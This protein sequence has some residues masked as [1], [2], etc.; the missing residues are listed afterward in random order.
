MRSI[1]LELVHELLR[2]RSSSWRAT[3]VFE[4][5]KH[6]ADLCLA[7]ERQGNR[8]LDCFV[9]Y[10][11]VAYDVQGINDRGTDVLL[12]YYV[13]SDNKE[14]SRFIAFQ[15]KS[16]DDL[17]A[18]TY[19]R[20]IKAQYTDSS[21]AFGD[22]LDQY[23]ILLCTNKI[24]HEDKIRQIKSAF[25][26]AEVITVI[27]PTY[28]H[29]FLALSPLRIN[30]VV[31]ILLRDDDIVYEKAINSLMQYTPTEIA[32]Y[33]ALVYEEMFS[34]SDKQNIDGI[35]DQN[36]IIDIFNKVPDYPKEYFNYLE[37][38]LTGDRSIEEDDDMD[39]LNEIVDMKRDIRI[40]FAEAVESLDGSLFSIDGDSQKYIIYLDQTLPIQAIILENMVR[41]D[42][43]DDQLLTYLFHNLR[44]L[45]HFGIEDVDK[46][47]NWE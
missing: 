22:S 28:A 4:K 44:I 42:Y 11:S 21:V 27:D 23:Y 34:K 13:Q 45:E 35:L 20:D 3:E 36:F 41:Y 37:S 24:A 17:Q 26:T 14:E 46:N 38:S 25:A 9:K 19:L 12:R 18:K 47:D 32:V 30:S 15:I 33:L 40:R 7:L 5:L 31:S 43:K 6:N 29:S 10:K 2:F 8:M 39:I 16:F 1:L